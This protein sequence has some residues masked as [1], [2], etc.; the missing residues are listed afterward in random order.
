[1]SK[2][3]V[4]LPTSPTPMLSRII[5]LLRCRTVWDRCSGRA[6]RMKEA[7]L[8]VTVSSGALRAT[9][10]APGHGEGTRTPVSPALA[11]AAP[12]PRCRQARGAAPA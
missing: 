10:A 9:T 4:V 12:R 11:A 7:K 1:M 3:R 2:T 6:A 5:L 8:L